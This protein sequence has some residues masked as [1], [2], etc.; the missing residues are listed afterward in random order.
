M[1]SLDTRK[2]IQTLL[3]I[4]ADGWLGPVSRATFD[5]LASAPDDSIWPPSPAPVPVL[6]QG[7]ASA[8]PSSIL[9]TAFCP[10]FVSVEGNDLVVRNITAT[11]FGGG[12]DAGDNGQTESGV[13]NDGSN[14]A[15]MGCALPI[16]STEAATKGS[17]LAFSEAHIPW[18]TKVKV[19]KQIQGEATAITV[20]LI[21][22]GPLVRVYPTHALD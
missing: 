5:R 9:K 17:P 21:D 19:W 6:A 16:R 20:S 15:L 1:N 12:H 13:I 10:W 8:A 14:P 22:N 11:C 7:E 3:G 18:G 2:A 4:T